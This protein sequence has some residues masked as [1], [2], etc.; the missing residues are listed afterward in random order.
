M[1]ALFSCATSTVD[2]SGHPER[3]TSPGSFPSGPVERSD[4]IQVVSSSV[5]PHSVREDVFRLFQTKPWAPQFNAHALDTLSMYETS[6]ANAGITLSSTIFDDL[7]PTLST[8]WDKV[9]AT[10]KL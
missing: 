6:K 5:A 7:N 10:V 2:S 8:E 3:R 1:L 9:K 4:P